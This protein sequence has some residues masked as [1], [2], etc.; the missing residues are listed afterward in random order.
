[1]AN[2]SAQSIFGKY[3][4]LREESWTRKRPKNFS[5]QLNKIFLPRGK[6]VQRE[7]NALLDGGDKNIIAKYDWGEKVSKLMK[8]HLDD[9]QGCFGTS[10]KLLMIFPRTSI[11]HSHRSW[12]LRIYW[13]EGRVAILIL[14][15]DDKIKWFCLSLF[16][17]WS[18]SSCASP[19]FLFEP[20][21]FPQHSSTW[22]S[23]SLIPMA[24]CFNHA[25]KYVQHFLVDV[26]E[27]IKPHPSYICR[28]KKVNLKL[29][30][31]AALKLS[32][33]DLTLMRKKKKT[34]K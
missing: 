20:P 26:K 25:N 16:P 8:I 10:L 9:I 29:L 21:T 31:E 22:A 2:S 32:E 6:I 5:I 33:K 17:S 13:F 27:E 23:L 3:Q 30:K 1:M 15:M 24:D 11:K 34:K 14:L 12:S 4:F 19:V 28:H 18:S 7:H